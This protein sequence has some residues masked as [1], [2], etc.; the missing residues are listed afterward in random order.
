MFAVKPL[1][2]TWKKYLLDGSGK[3]V[4]IRRKQFPLMPF[5]AVALYSMQGT[6]ADPSMVAYWMF[7]Q[8]CSETIQ[9]LI[10]YVLRDALTSKSTIADEVCEFDIESARID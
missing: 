3:Y 8:R 5:E 1:V 7:P 2:R 9:W 4:S 10:V 6:T